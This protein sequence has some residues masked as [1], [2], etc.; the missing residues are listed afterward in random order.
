MWLT[1]TVIIYVG[2]VI[3]IICHSLTIPKFSM[4]PYNT[5]LTYDS[6]FTFVKKCL[7]LGNTWSLTHPPCQF[8][9]ISHYCVLYF[10]N[11]SDARHMFCEVVQGWQN[12]GCKSGMKNSYKTLTTSVLQNYSLYLDGAGRDKM[13]Y[14]K[15]YESNNFGQICKI[16]VSTYL[17]K[18]QYDIS[19]TLG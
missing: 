8:V 1:N 19:K 2:G 17:I 14:F 16:W 4:L 5:P 18:V 9:C 13:K 15:L 11:I 3:Y 10:C 6:F 7:S 12:T